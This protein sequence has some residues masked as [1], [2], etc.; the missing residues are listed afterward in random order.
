MFL[1]M[2][3]LFLTGAPGFMVDFLSEPVIAAFMSSAALT[4]SAGQLRVWVFSLVMC[5]SRFVQRF[6]GLKYKSDA[7]TFYQYLDEWFNNVNDYAYVAQRSCFVLKP[8][9]RSNDLALA[10]VCTIFL[11]ILQML[12]K[13]FVN[14]KTLWRRVI[15]L[16]CVCTSYSL[17]L[18]RS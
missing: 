5:L 13:R 3:F 12:T 17:L 1:S 18:M 14:S 11:F 6:F 15:W 9:H 4:I 2:Y 7:H 10:F 8:S 16:I